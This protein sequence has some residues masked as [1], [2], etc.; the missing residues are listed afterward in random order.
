MGNYHAQ[1]LG[2]KGVER[3]LLYPVVFDGK[4]RPQDVGLYNKRHEPLSIPVLQ[5]N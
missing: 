3:P 5:K 1:F 2:G 4:S